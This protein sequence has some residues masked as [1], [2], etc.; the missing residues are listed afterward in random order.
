MIMPLEPR[1]R[2]EKLAREFRT[3]RYVQ[4]PDVFAPTQAEA[5]LRC[6]SEEVPWGLAY[7]DDGAVFLRKQQLQAMTP[8][9]LRELE[10]N[11]YRRA[12][13]QYQYAYSAYPVLDA[14]LQGWHEVPLLNEFLEG[15]NSE[16]MLHYIRAL[17]GMPAVV[18]ADAQATRFGPGQFLRRHND[19]SPP[20]ETW[21]VAY[22]Y[23]LTP[24]WQPDWGG[25]LHLL[26]TNG[27]VVRGLLPRFNALNLMAVPQPHLVSAVAPFA[28]AYRYAITGWFRSR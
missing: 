4:I 22:V 20:S 1:P 26:D 23:N 15:L 24:Q 16:P 12:R 14:Y 10:A 28:G 21:L 5:L 18:K 19:R 3:Q 9:Q 13:T 7:Y 8:E 27:D 2:V 17:T 6:L 11:V 25:Y